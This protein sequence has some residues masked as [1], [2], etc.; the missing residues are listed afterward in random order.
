MATA[1]PAT[2]PPSHR[3]LHHLH[4]ANPTGNGTISRVAKLPLARRAVNKH[5]KNKYKKERNNIKGNLTNNGGANFYSILI[6]L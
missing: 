3:S 1:V 6:L 4:T 5:N 2:A